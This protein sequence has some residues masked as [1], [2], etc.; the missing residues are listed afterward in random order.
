MAIPPASSAEAPVIAA[1]GAAVAWPAI[2]A[3]ATIAASLTLILIGLG[4]GLGLSAV[5]PWK[6]G[7]SPAG[8]TIA[9]GI[10]LIVTQ[11]L[12]A[13]V[14]GYVTGRLR[15]RWP[16]AHS[17]EAFFRDTAHGLIVWGVAA[18]AGAALLVAA[19]SSALGGGA[20]LVAGAGAAL[21]EAVRAYDVE[22][23]LRRP[24][25]GEGV[26]T[27]DGDQ[28]SEVLHILAKDVVTGETTD[29]DREYLVH[30]VAA[31]TGLSQTEARKRVD[32]ISARLKQ[33]A[34]TARKSASA[35]FLFGAFSMLIGAFIAA[36]AAA[37]GGRQ[38]DEQ[39]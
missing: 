13:G 33:A 37:L 26:G 21:P 27:A 5:S 25:T 22:L 11:W 19:G 39:G 38:R 7:P 10:W 29:D 18:L 36:A 23:L 34:D 14:G 15:M 30:V 35:F 9:A 20:R 16:D 28:G 17:D 2:F 4:A 32:E 8:F 1:T 12:S 24:S 6:E 31:R 3:G